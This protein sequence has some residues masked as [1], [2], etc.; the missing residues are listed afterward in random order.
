[1]VIS[2]RDTG[3]ICLFTEEDVVSNDNTVARQLY[4]Y[5]S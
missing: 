5:G 1:M 2:S 4:G 3:Q